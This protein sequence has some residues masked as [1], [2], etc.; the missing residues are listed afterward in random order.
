MIWLIFLIWYSNSFSYEEDFENSEGDED[1]D[2][3]DE[4]DATAAADAEPSPAPAADETIAGIYISLPA[5]IPPPKTTH[6]CQK[7]GNWK[8]NARLT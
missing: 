8:Q 2:E 4:E 3:E 5:F 6:A 7:K 1:D